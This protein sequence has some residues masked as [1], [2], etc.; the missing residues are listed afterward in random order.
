MNQFRAFFVP[1]LVTLGFVISGIIFLNGQTNLSTIVLELGLVLGSIPLVIEFVKNILKKKYGVDIIALVA[2]V[3]AFLLHEY[4]AGSVIVLMLSGGE[5]LEAFAAKRS[6]QELTKLLSLGEDLEDVSVDQVAIND[7]LVVKVGE[8]IPVDGVVIAGTSYVDESSI[9]GESEPVL[10][11]HGQII[12]SGSVN[13]TAVLEIRATHSSSESQYQ[14]I[15]ALVK[16]AQED[17]A[18]LARLADRYAIAFSVITF[19]ISIAAWVFSGDPTRFLAVLVVATPCPLILAVPIALIS[20]MSKSASRGVIVKNGGALETLGEAKGFVF[21]K[22]G[23]LTLGEPALQSITSL[24]TMSET[25]VVRI[26]ASIDQLSMHVFARS[27]VRYA[28]EQQIPFSF[29]ET[30][31]EVIGSGVEGIID[32]QK[33]FFGKLSFLKEHGVPVSTEEESLHD[34]SQQQGIISVYLSTQTSLVGKILFEDKIR[35][36]IKEMFQEIQHHK[37]QEVHMLTGDRAAVAQHIAEELHIT[38]VKAEMK[39]EDKLNEIKLLRERL[40]PI[41]MVGDG[42]NDAPAMAAADV[43]IALAAYGSSASSEAG[44]IVITVNNMLRVHDVLHIAQR[45]MNIAK[46]SIYVGIGVSILLMLVASVGLIPPIVGAVLQ[47]VL[48]VAVILNA[49]RVSFE[50]IS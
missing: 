7:H 41:V 3:T 44:D 27:L 23:T 46:Q 12:F 17:R 9:T 13:Q 10:K 6:T 11:D 48:D 40:H 43:S 35:P 47:E 31:S 5:A 50:D 39:P 25:D 1:G 37:I 21:D 32:N 26:A 4:I 2:I 36:E 28:T 16:S 42:I 29:P 30:F 49:L 14:R 19:A 33:Y 22:T 45:T 8:I 15:V 20:G 18:P 24:S 38:H 34:A